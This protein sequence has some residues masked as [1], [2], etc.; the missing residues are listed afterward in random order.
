[1]LKETIKYVDYNGTDREFVAYFNLNKSEILRMEMSVKGGMSGF[2][3]SIVD[4]KDQIALIKLWDELIDL[5]YGVKTID[6][7]F[8]KRAEDLEAFKATAAYSELYMKLATDADYAANFIK[9]IFP[10][11]LV[12]QA[13]KEMKALPAVE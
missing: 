11:D 4:T 9:G 13:E 5:A 12:E 8:T 3:Q 7:G 6:G 10:K 1:M 2:I